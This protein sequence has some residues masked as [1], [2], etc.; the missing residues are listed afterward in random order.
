MAIKFLKGNLGRAIYPLLGV[1]VGGMALVMTLSL[2]DGAK[3]LIEKDLS[4]IGSNRVLL[5]GDFN[6]R[7]LELVERL[8]FVEYATFPEARALEFNNLFRGYT[9]AAFNAM[10]LPILRADEV[11][12]D[13]SQ[14]K[15][16]SIGSS[17]T[18]ETLGGKK[19]F[20]IRGYYSEES[21]F[22]TMK[23]GNRVLMNSLTFNRYFKKANYNTMVAAFRES[24]DEFDYI[25]P[26][27]R[28]LN[29]FRTSGTFV[30]VL[31]TPDVYKKVDKI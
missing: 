12:L 2:G 28:E 25:S 9:N 6:T 26:L 23:L 29:K 7:D 16:V 19:E 1:V 18:F 8:P 4:A 14:F 22:Q 11:I 15:K 5:G 20:R 3:N 10:N 31:E 17:M 24:K 21:P 13:R 27:L 30:K